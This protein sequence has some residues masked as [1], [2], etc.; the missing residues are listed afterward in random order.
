[1]NELCI[2]SLIATIILWKVLINLFRSKIKSKLCISA[3]RIS[4]QT[5]K[6]SEIIYKSS[7][8]R[9]LRLTV[10]LLTNKAKNLIGKAFRVTQDHPAGWKS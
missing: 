5:Y 7:E 9:D 2:K 3:F 8:G 4:F 10:S 1:M 6:T